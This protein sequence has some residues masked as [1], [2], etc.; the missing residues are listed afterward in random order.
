M[1]TKTHKIDERKREIKEEWW[2]RRR[3]AQ[4]T[5][6]CDRMKVAQ[7]LATADWQVDIACPYG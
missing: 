7:A 3:P 4:V 5:I 6:R 1:V 2:A